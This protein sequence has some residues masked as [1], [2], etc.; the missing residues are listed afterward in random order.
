MD[1][2]TDPIWEEQTQL[3]H[4][5]TQIS[6]FADT[7]LTENEK[8]LTSQSDPR[9]FK[10]NLSMYDILSELGQGTQGLVYRAMH[11]KL[12]RHVAI[13]ILQPQYFKNEQ[14]LSHFRKEAQIISRIKHENVATV[15]DFIEHEG[16]YYLVMELIEGENLVEKIKQGPLSIPETLTIIL[17][18][19]EGI[20]F[21]HNKNILHLD[22][23][24]SNVIMDTHQNPVLV[25]FGLSR[26]QRQG[27]DLRLKQVI[28]TPA[29]M[30]PEQFTKGI[31]SISKQTDLYS[32]GVIFYHLLTGNLPFKGKDISELRQK[33]LLESPV[34]PSQINSKIPKSLDA[35]VL[36]LISK[37]PQNRY[38]TA[39]DVIDEIRRFNE[40]LPVKAYQYKTISLILGW[41]RRNKTL[42]LITGILLMTL[43]VSGAYYL[44]KKK[45]ETPEWVPVFKEDFD[46]SFFHSWKGFIGFPGE[47]LLGI[48]TPSEFNHQFASRIKTG[49]FKKDAPLVL[50]SK[51]SIDSSIKLSFDMI[52]NPQAESQFGFFVHGKPVEDKWGYIFIW[53]NNQI[54]LFKDHLHHFLLGSEPFRFEPNTQYRF[55]IESAKDKVSLYINN[56]LIIQFQDYVNIF[57]PEES[58]VGFFSRKSDIEID[59]VSLIQLRQPFLITPLDIGNRFYH[60]GKNRDAILEY[61]RVIEKYSPHAIAKEALYHRGICY[62][63]DRQF[64]R[65]L[66]DFDSLLATPISKDLKSKVNFHR[67][68]CLLYTQDTSQAFNIFKM[69]VN[70]SPENWLRTVTAEQLLSY[71]KEFMPLEDYPTAKMIEQVFLFNLEMALCHPILFVDIPKSLVLFFY[72]HQYYQDTIRLLDQMIKTYGYKRDLTAFCLW[73]KGNAYY[74]WARIDPGRK[75]EYERLS[76]HFLNRIFEQFAD[77]SIYNLYACESLAKLYRSKNEFSKANEMEKKRS[78][79]QDEIFNNTDIHF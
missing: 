48:D 10:P 67:A 49:S 45:L 14:F 68:V 17:G 25:D 3:D 11:K 12:G 26:L 24:T 31:D 76:I 39:Q 59:N 5:N 50:S 4:D 55:E 66:M 75:E 47:H 2:K 74:E 77:I 15:Y 29:Y 36:K 7:T 30:A 8:T 73:K 9:K 20:R 21:T 79:L 64:M 69:L 63:K 51:K 58:Y 34:P 40:G 1:H 18:I 27:E 78:L 38:E 72:D 54:H 13:K 37:S 23:K 71:T 57:T 19:L 33:I 46:K 60:L 53:E 32:I 28:G 43:V 65:A 70:E 6:D 52:F 22:L 62:L 16:A 41:M 44:Y 35:I 42:S 56:T 61:S